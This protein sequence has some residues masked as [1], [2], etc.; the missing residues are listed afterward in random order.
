MKNFPLILT[1]L[2]LSACGFHPVYG[3]NKY[4]SVGVE[5]KLASIQIENI[6]N[7]EGQYLRNALID[8]FYRDERP[9]SPVYT[10]SIDPINEGKR[11]LD[12]TKN[13]DATRGQL[14]LQ[15]AFQL[16]NIATGQIVLERNIQTIASYNILSSEFTNS[17][18]EQN[19][20]ENGLEDLARQIEQQIDLMFKHDDLK[21][22]P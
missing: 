7:R 18:S 3:V 5:D 15:T 1:L 16:K 21:D 20:R 8:R 13:S 14:K 4:T 9:E 10:L 17:V 12:I 22:V 11:D 2:F 19:T 6:P